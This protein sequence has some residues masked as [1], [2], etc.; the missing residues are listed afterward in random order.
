MN[1]ILLCLQILFFSLYWKNKIFIFILLPISA[2]NLFF[3]YKNQKKINSKNILQLSRLGM[4]VFMSF[5]LLLNYFFS[6]F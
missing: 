5:L 3:E 4:L 1:I 6:F 2:F